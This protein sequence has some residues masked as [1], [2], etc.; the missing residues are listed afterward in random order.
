MKKKESFIKGIVYLLIS[1]IF[2]KVVGL[3]YKL[4]LTNKNGFGDEGNAIYSSGFQIYALLLAFSS[5]GVPSAIS[6]LV[7]ERLAIGDSKGAHQIFKI[8]FVAFAFLGGLGSILLFIGAKKIAVDWIQMP[9]SENSIICLAPSI[10]FVSIIAVFRGYFNGRQSFSVTAK[11]QSIEQIFKTILTIVLVE[12][13]TLISRRNICVMAG[14][15]NLATTIATIISFCYVYIYYK[16]KSPEIGQEIK[17]TINYKPTRIRKTLKKVLSVAIPISLSSIISSFN[18]NIDSFTVV[19]FLKRIMSEGEAKTQYGI[20]S[21]KVDTLSSVV[22]SLNVAFVTAFIPNIAKSF[23][24]GDIIK[25]KKK[26]YIFIFITL[27]MGI[28]ITLIM[29][30]FPNKILELLFPNANSGELYLKMSSIGI[31]FMLLNQTIN[32]VLQSI[33]KVNIPPISSATGMLLKLLCNVIL[34][35]NH[36]FGIFGAII[37]NIIGNIV[38]CFISSVVLIYTLERK[39]RIPLLNKVI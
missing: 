16:I 12:A 25:T 36:K 18:K 39:K 30:F 5:T 10:F 20:L 32:A 28:P 22:L 2:I 8:A 29:F 13:V 38:A 27:I 14:A 11:S 34:I 19:R 15:A 26:I 33:G 23:A 1:Q 9:E 21:G 17:Q 7:A 31:I 4:Y 6:K 24:K 35:P 37:G 3:A